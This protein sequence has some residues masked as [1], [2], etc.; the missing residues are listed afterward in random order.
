[1]SDTRENFVTLREVAA[2]DLPIF[3]EHQSDPESAEMADFPSRSWESFGAHWEKIMKDESVTLR[4]ILYGGDVAG[5]IVSW[6]QEG[7][8]EVG[9][10][11]GKEFWGRGVATR[12]LAQFL[13]LIPTRPLYAYVAKHN[14]ASLRVLQ[15][16]GFAIQTEI[17]DDGMIQLRVDKRAE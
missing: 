16:C 11:I 12:A 3:F 8:R 2:V 7:E 15:K 14:I 6:E 17:E 9:Y 10:W 4:T 1:M 5:N 13:R